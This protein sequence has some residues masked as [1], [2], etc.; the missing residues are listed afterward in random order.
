MVGRLAG[1]QRGVVLDSLVSEGVMEVL[2][3]IV[4]ENAS[5]SS[6]GSSRTAESGLA[7]LLLADLAAGSEAAKVKSAT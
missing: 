4:Q 6:P 2:L 1:D 7:L 3:A 5:S